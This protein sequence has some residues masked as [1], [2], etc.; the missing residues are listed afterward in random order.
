MSLLY[1]VVARGQVVLAEFTDASGNF[2]TVTRLLLGKIDESESKRMSLLQGE[3]Q[4][5]YLVH[6]GIT[7]LCLT[8]ALGK[9]EPGKLRLA[10]SFLDSVR[11]AFFT[12]H[13]ERAHSA[14]A[15]E[16]N[17]SFAPVLRSQMEGFNSGKADVVGRVNEKL[18]AV[19]NVMVQNIEQ[20]L[21]RGEK[22]ELL[23]DKTDQLNQQVACMPPSFCHPLD[24]L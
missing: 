12:A 9:S 16:L 18:D 11:A 22:L 17:E 24:M 3:H 21:E 13:G 8:D 2:P 14:I 5:H 23:V 15:F 20:V 1:S 6:D 19:K 10:F 4:F 7:F